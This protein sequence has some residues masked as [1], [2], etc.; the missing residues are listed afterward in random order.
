MDEKKLQNRL[1]YLSH[2]LFIA[3]PDGKEFIRLMKLQHVI[4][5]TFPQPPHVIEQ[6]GGATGWAAYREGQLTLIRAIEALAQNYHD[7]LEAENTTGATK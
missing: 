5:P 3:N 1:Q 4:T 6:H 7:K 2:A